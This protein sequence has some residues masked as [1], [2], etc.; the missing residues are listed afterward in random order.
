VAGA[1]GF[2]LGLVFS[3]VLTELTWRLA[4][5]LPAALALLALLAGCAWCRATVR[6]HASAAASMSPAPSA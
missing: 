5:L 4:F 3:G 1:A 6:R 2:S